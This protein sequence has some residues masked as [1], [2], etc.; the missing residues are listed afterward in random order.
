MLARGGPAAAAPARHAAAAWRDFQ[1]GGHAKNSAFCC[2]CSY[3]K[4]HRSSAAIGR[5]PL[6]LGGS[7]T[8]LTRDHPAAVTPSL[9]VT[10]TV[11]A[12]HMYPTIALP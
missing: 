10:G 12:G 11:C 5:F 8:S 4:F 9:Y 2:S 6:P 3:C 7:L 1:H